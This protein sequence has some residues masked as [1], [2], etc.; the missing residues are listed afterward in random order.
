MNLP[1][2][3][4]ESTAWELGFFGLPSRIP[5]PADVEPSVANADPF[6][7]DH[8]LRAIELMGAEAS[9]PWKSFAAAAT[10]F[11]DLTEA[12]EDVEIGRARELLD[13]VE[14]LHPGTAFSLFHQ[15][16]VARHEARHEDAIDLY[17]AA[18]AKVPRLA[19]IWNNLGVVLALVGRRDDAIRAF[20]KALDCAPNDPTALEGLTQLRVLIKLRQAQ[21]GNQVAYVDVPTFRRMASE[22]LAPLARDP[23]QLLAFA[24]QLLRDGFVPDVG[25]RALQAAAELRPADRRTL[26]LLGAAYRAVGEPQQARDVFHRCTQAHPNE[27]EP[28]FRLAEIRNL[29]GDAGSARA[30]VDR[31]LE[32]DPNFQPALSLRFEVKPGE[33]DPAKEQQLSDFGE[34]RNSWMAFVLASSLCR[35]RGDH[36]RAV[37]WAERAL[38]LAPELEEP[39]LHFTAVLG[40]ARDVTTL[41][42]IVKPRVESGQFT[43]LLDWQYAHVL[44]QLGLSRDAVAVLR[45]AAAASDAADEFKAACAT[46]IEAWSGLLTGSGIRLEVH[47]S[48]ILL[49]DVLLT[50]PDGDGG[51][52]LGAGASLPVETAFPWGAKSSETMVALQQGQ[53]GSARTPQPLG[54]FRVSRIQTMPTEGTTVQCEIAARPD[55]ALHFRASQNGRRLPVA[56]SPPRQRQG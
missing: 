25:L 7:M 31:A 6:E 44:R 5:W 28:F 23:E 45:K 20:H 39:L 15:A 11:D 51:V 26:L 54:V 41:A 9:P 16:F 3:W 29:M 17:Q 1:Y 13:E 19:P 48:G 43:R 52:I 30:A 53:T 42:K 38:Q 12:L 18:A 4:I 56:W 33:H 34:Q 21:D 36:G 22:Q 46:T 55:G 32:I 8:L 47:P 10:I 24:E 2:R 49:R 35:E 37:R 14:R 40:D 27:P 50:L